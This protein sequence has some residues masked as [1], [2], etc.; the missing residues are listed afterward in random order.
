MAGV[1]KGRWRNV[2]SLLR[3]AL[4]QAGTAVAP[5]RHREPRS[6]RSGSPK[7]CAS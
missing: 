2:L 7:G 5:G 6:P 3:R 4:A 1:S